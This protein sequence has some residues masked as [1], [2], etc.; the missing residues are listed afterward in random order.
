MTQ[1]L[2]WMTT[3]TALVGFGLSLGLNP[4]LYGATADMLARGLPVR[5]RL[6]FMISGLWAG[7]TALFLLLQAFNPT[8]MVSVIKHRAQDDLFNRTVD[9][10]VGIIFLVLAGGVAAWTVRVRTLPSPKP[11]PVKNDT[12]PVG[13][14][15][16][17]LSSAVIGFT[18]LPIMYLVGRM[19]TSLTPHLVPRLFVY[20]VFLVALASPFVA[21][22]WAWARFPA[23]TDRVSNF[24]SRALQRDYRW[25]AVVLCA[26]IGIV[27]LIFAAV[28]RG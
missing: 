17:G 3:I 16:I 2:S 4:A 25:A 20:A 6:G 24:Y 9:L 18:T 1:L 8:S 14:F 28:G 12:R 13:Y 22:A 23:Y 26:T 5:A 19:T 15:F 21:I 11:K 7:A 10:A 27:F